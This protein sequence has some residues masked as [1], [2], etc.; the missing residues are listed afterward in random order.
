MFVNLVWPQQLANI[1]LCFIFLIQIIDGNC[2]FSHSL[3]KLANVV[4]DQQV[5]K[6]T[7]TSR[8]VA[9]AGTISK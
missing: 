5:D 3:A 1:P 6:H 7:P 4:Q 2:I 8:W 9:I